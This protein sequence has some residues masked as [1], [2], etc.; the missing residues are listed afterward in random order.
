MERDAHDHVDTVDSCLISTA[1]LHE[2]HRLAHHS[3]YVGNGSRRVDVGRRPAL[4]AGAG[5]AAVR[6]DIFPGHTQYF[7]VRRAR[8]S[9]RRPSPTSCVRPHPRVVATGGRS[10]TTRAAKSN[11]RTASNASVGHRST[12]ASNWDAAI[13]TADAMVGASRLSGLRAGRAPLDRTRRRAALDA[14]PCRRLEKPPDAG[15]PPLD[16]S[17]QRGPGPRNPRFARRRGG[18]RRPICSAGSSPRTPGSSRGSGRP[19]RACWPPTARKGALASTAH[20]AARPRSVLRR[21]EHALRLLDRATAA[22]IRPARRRRIVGDVRDAAYDRCPR[23]TAG[24]AHA[25]GA[26]RGGQHRTHPRPSRHGQR[27]RRA[28]APGPG[29]PAGPLTG[30]RPLGRGGRRVPLAL[31]H[32]RRPARDRRHRDAARHQRAGGR[33]RGGRH[34]A[35]AASVG[36]LGPHPPLDVGRHA[37]ASPA[38][39]STPSPTARRAEHSSSARDKEVREVALTPS[40]DAFALA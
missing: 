15:R 23:G 20:A 7:A 6:E 1:A 35:S 30:P 2:V 31:R 29:L 25:P 17:P 14:A 38:S 22:P 11:A 39:P 27:G 24:A 4:D 40:H 13:V 10:S 19:H 37:P 34:D 5:T 16:R 12:S 9:R 21:S 26:R 3:I 36:S 18:H 32:H 33:P 28:G 8:S